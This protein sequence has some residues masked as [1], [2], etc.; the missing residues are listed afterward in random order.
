MNENAI[1]ALVVDCAVEPHR[2]WG[3]GRLETVGRMTFGEA[4]V[5]DGITRV[6]RALL[7]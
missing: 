2:D 5:R 1:G 4:S 3:P 7:D 6:V